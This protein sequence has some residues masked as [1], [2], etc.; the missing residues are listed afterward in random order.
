LIGKI[1][2]AFHVRNGVNDRQFHEKPPR[3]AHLHRRE[4]DVGRTT[5]FSYRMRTKR[6]S[7]HSPSQ[8]LFRRR[9][10]L[11]LSA[12][13]GRLSPKFCHHNSPLDEQ[14][15]IVAELAAEA[16]RIETVRAHIPRFEA[17]IQRVLDRVWG[18][19]TE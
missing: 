15:G 5:H 18:T 3:M 4:S 13:I 17:K 14:R 1:L 9:T 12:E 11:P 10:N 2:L 16:A 8:R 7:V 19:N 6:Q